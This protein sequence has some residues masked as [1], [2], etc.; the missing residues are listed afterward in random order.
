M[1]NTAL[2]TNYVMQDMRFSQLCLHNFKSSVI[3]CHVQ[4]FTVID[5]S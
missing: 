2:E 5:V 1:K 3:Q 4:W